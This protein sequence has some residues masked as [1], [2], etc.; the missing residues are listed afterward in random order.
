MS[1]KHL[2]PIGVLA[3]SSDPTGASTGDIYFNTTGNVY[4]QYTGSAW[5]NLAVQPTDGAGGGRIFTG[6]NTPTSP[7]TGDIW[8]DSTGTTTFPNITAKSLVLST[9]TN[10]VPLTINGNSSPFTSN[11]IEFYNNYTSGSS[12]VFKVSSNGEVFADGAIYS[13]TGLA[14]QIG[15]VV[16]IYGNTIC[17]ALTANGDTFLNNVTAGNITCAGLSTDT[18]TI[19]GYQI[20]GGPLGINTTGILT[21]GYATAAVTTSS[22]V[23]PFSVQNIINITPST[24]STLTIDSVPAAGTICNL[25]INNGASTS[26]VMTFATTASNFRVSSTTLPLGTASR[27][28]VMGFIS[29]GSKLNEISRTVALIG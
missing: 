16:D 7:I 18:G 11:F 14:V 29:D 23:L 9:D 25:I 12:P 15:F 1:R 2:T 27:T 22:T 6:D 28:Y 8:I 3:Q 5:V 17:E 10:I 19:S 20:V 21:G 24:S 13:L 26:R 4:K